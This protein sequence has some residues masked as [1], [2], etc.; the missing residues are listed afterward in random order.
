MVC[1]IPVCVPIYALF[2]SLRTFAHK[3]F[4]RTEFLVNFIHACSKRKDQRLTFPEDKKKKT[5]GGRGYCVFNFF[6][7][8][9]VLVVCL[10]LVGFVFCFVL[11]CFFFFKIRCIQRPRVF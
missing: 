7:I 4:P 2:L 9:F 11:F 8:Y 1:F 6:F 3:V 5:E 10:F